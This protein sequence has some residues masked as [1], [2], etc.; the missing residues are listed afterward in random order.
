MACLWLGSWLDTGTSAFLWL[1]IQNGATA[2]AL[3]TANSLFCSSVD[4]KQACFF[5]SY[6]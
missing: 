1:P 4:C 3:L 2:I 5:A 6:A